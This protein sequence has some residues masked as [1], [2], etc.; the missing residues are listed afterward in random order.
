MIERLLLKPK[1]TI[2][3]KHIRLELAEASLSMMKTGFAR[4]EEKT[5]T[6]YHLFSLELPLL[7]EGQL[8]RKW[9]RSKQLWH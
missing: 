5:L 6:H 3:N 2:T 9:P 8:L 4:E 7:E 1:R